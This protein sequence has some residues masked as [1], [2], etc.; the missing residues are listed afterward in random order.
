[1]QSMMRDTLLRRILELP[2]GV[3]VG[4]RIGEHS[5]DIT[6]VVAWGDGEFGGLQCDFRDI[7]DVM[8]DL[9]FMRAVPNRTNPSC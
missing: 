6:D 4:V 7:R 8:A 5:L 1:M 9:E 3:D 2:Q